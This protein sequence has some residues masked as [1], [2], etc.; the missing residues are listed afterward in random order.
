MRLRSV[1][2][3]LRRPPASAGKAGE[4]V[5]LAHALGA[6]APPGVGLVWLARESPEPST[7]V[8]V[9]WPRPTAHGSARPGRRR[10][11][12]PRAAVAHAERLE[13]RLGQEVVRR[14]VGPGARGSAIGGRGLSSASVTAAGGVD[15]GERRPAAR[16]TPATLERAPRR[17]RR[18][19]ARKAGLEPRPL[20][21]LAPAVEGQRAERPDV[22]RG[23]EARRR[24]AAT[25]CR[26]PTRPRSRGPS[27]A[28]SPVWRTSVAAS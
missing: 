22:A 20:A 9:R 13:Q 12:C 24:R 17:P 2:L 25:G 19:S 18:R 5:L 10:A 15:A 8:G 6:A 21:A 14:H 27:T 4:V 1:P 26:T 3:R 11:C 23:L 28:R 7:T 16:S